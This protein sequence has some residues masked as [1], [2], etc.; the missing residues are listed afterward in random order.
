MRAS[1]VIICA[2]MSLSLTEAFVHFP[3]F[4]S[5]NEDFEPLGGSI[6]NKRVPYYENIWPFSVSLKLIISF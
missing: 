5:P 3:I 6:L 1:W 4:E 2:L